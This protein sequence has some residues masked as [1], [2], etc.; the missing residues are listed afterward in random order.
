MA[1]L[2]TDDID[3]GTPFAPLRL[4][5]G[6]G[7]QS[8]TRPV[9]RVL[10][11]AVTA[12][13]LG[14]LALLG[15]LR[16][17]TGRGVAGVVWSADAGE[18]IEEDTT[19]DPLEK[20]GSVDSV[21]QNYP[22]LSIKKCLH[23]NLALKGPD[24]GDEGMIFHAD[25][26]NT[27]DSVELVVNGVSSYK[28]F[29]PR[30][31]GMSGKYG[32][33]NLV[34]G[35]SVKVTFSVR[36]AI[37][38]E[39]VVEP[40]F[41]LTFFDLDQGLGGTS[42]ESVT[43]SDFT[44]FALADDIE[45]G[46]GSEVKEI[47]NPDG[48]RT[49]RSSTF[50][51]G[52]DNP[53]DPANL[54]KQQKNRAVSFR[55]RNFRSVDVT[56][57]ASK[58][59]EPRFFTFVAYPALICNAN[60]N[61]QHLADL[62]QGPSDTGVSADRN[63]IFQQWFV[64]PGDTVNVGDEL[65]SVEKQDES[66]HVYRAPVKGQVKAIQAGL[67]KGDLLSQRLDDKTIA[68]ISHETMAALPV[69]LGDAKT[70]APA[71]EIFKKWHVKK[72][73]IVMKGD[74]IADVQDKQ[75]QV[76]T[77]TASK[78][79]PVTAIQEDLET[80]MSIDTVEDGNLA[81][82]GRF[83]SL[84][85]AA[86]SSVTEVPPD[87]TFVRYLV[88]VGDSVSANTPV[89][90]VEC[91]G[92][93]VQEV[94][95]SAPGTVTARQENLVK[96]MA[97]DEAMLDRNIVVVGGSARQMKKFPPLEVEEGQHPAAVPAGMSFEAWHK[98]VDDIVKAHDPLLDVRNANGGLQTL[99]ATGDGVVIRR[100]DKLERGMKIDEVM[101][102]DN[103]MVIG[104]L[105]PLEVSEGESPSNVPVGD[106]TFKEYQVAPGQIVN[107]GDTVAVV[108]DSKSNDIPVQAT[109][110]GTVKSRQE[111]LV[112]GASIPGVM[113]DRD[114][115]VI[116]KYPAVQPS[117]PRQT[118][119]SAPPGAIFDRW[120]VEEGERV[121]QGD[122]IARVTIPDSNTPLGRRL[123]PN[124]GKTM[125]ILSPTWGTVNNVQPLKPGASVEMQQMG[126]NIACLD[127]GPPWWLGI[128]AVFLLL[129]CCLGLLCGV[130]KKP[131]P[132]KPMPVAEPEPAPA[133][134]KPDGLRL[135]FE[136]GKSVRTVYA[137]RRPLGIK[138][139][140]KAPIVA[141]D[142]TIN[143]YARQELGVKDG[144]K[145]RRI[146]DEELY[147]NPNF[148]EVNAK[149]THYMK[150][151]ELW[152][153]P[154]DFKKSHNSPEVQTVEFRTRPIGIEFTNRAPIKVSKIYPGSPAQA[155]GVQEGMFVTRI[156]DADVNHNTNFREVISHFNE[157]VQPLDEGTIQGSTSDTENGR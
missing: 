129:C 83:P 82:I 48:S 121:E 66:V 22:K 105:K 88:N 81:V 57:A 117:G 79:G 140:F 123:I 132:Y 77:L 64:T 55:F 49:F 145:L 36:N 126:S 16:H 15:V 78:S 122:K 127:Q 135:D 96:G 155:Y 21:C 1:L 99:A 41:A 29:S 133:E 3:S 37:T 13:A 102:D 116:G 74:P 91:K 152:P 110:Y 147:D 71:G 137:K 59:L 52:A 92:G 69:G 50:G 12:A 130:M 68:V 61:S 124:F 14:G 86:D 104:K 141:H 107:E 51:T 10:L 112:D 54:S 56:F 76:T 58:G 20:A 67:K 43:I 5:A 2:S 4:P 44:S 75:A 156:G 87:C 118:G 115:V 60:Y 111:Q 138:H 26:T 23:N 85:V 28:P 63:D 119:I 100:Q 109:K 8:S 47:A 30:M 62:R 114:L 139:Q 154:I 33:L 136:D 153:L 40:Y 9:R 146:G 134:P 34:S 65:C 25:N 70:M 95:A 42:Q 144:W 128:L 113:E 89:A 143:S 108:R 7:A 90:E 31:N 151:F 142:F 106:Y 101:A 80:G 131:T 27:G 157:G 19:N 17:H 150:D 125:D 53:K 46:S 11:A 120:Y 6:T 149:L 84:P 98:D 45:P 38:K 39:P 94:E 24:K 148:D 103:L 72:D 73:D 97:I 35:S 18:I 93:Q 32:T